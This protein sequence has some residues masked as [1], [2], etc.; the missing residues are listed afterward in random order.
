MCPDGTVND[1]DP[2]TYQ[3]LIEHPVNER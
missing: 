1:G 2:D 3:W